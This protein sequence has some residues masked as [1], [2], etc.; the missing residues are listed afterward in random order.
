MNTRRWIAIGVAAVAVTTATAT[1][2]AAGVAAAATTLA[3]HAYRQQDLQRDLSAITATGVPGVLAEVRT[4]ARQLRGTSGV[5]DLDSRKPVNGNGYFRIGSNTKTFISVVVLQL[6]AEHRLSLDDPVGRWLPGAVHG[7]GNDAGKITVRE[8]L[9]HT[10]GLHNYTDDLQA[11]ITSVKAYR[12]LEF[13][14]FSRRD[15][16]SIALAHRPDFAPGAGWNY[17]NT[18]YILLGMII[19]RVTHDSWENEVTRRII[20]PLALRHTY[21]PGTS[22]RLPRPHAT[23]YLFFDKNTRID[24]TAENMSWAGSA[25]ALI[26]TATDLTRFWRAI[27]RGTLLRPA[28]TRQ[29]RR[30]V[31]ANSGDS[32]SVPGSRYGLG[33]FFIPLSCGGGYWSHEGDVPG[34]NTIGA[35]STDGRTTVVLS[36]NS[37]VDDP[38]LAAE[39]RLI[40]HV[41]CHRGHRPSTG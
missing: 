33:I 30:T 17:S 37:N 22:T 20:I 41:M 31:P 32:A 28:Q 19:G 5:A 40:D 26:S 2:A 25:G 18:N 27:G 8:L 14:Q 34:Y 24:T 23:G 21:A 29:M 39:Y 10:S 7:N 11:Q 9:Q 13:H 35:V 3:Q 36:L 12:K 6:V 38:V 1:S 15:L 16:L 4:G